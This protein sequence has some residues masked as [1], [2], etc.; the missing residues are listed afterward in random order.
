VANPARAAD[1][2]RP[3]LSSLLPLPAN[4]GKAA[5]VTAAFHE[6]KDSS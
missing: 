1:L 4:K 2:S 6:M 3:S 5:N